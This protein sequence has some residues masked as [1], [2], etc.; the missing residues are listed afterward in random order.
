MDVPILRIYGS[1]I[2]GVRTRAAAIL[3]VRAAYAG[4]SV[5]LTERDAKDYG[6][7]DFLPSPLINPKNLEIYSAN[8]LPSEKFVI[9]LAH[10]WN[11]DRRTELR[12]L[13][14]DYGLMVVSEGSAPKKAK[15]LNGD[16]KSAVVVGGYDGLLLKETTQIAKR[17]SKLPWIAAVPD[18]LPVSYSANMDRAKKKLGSLGDKNWQLPV[19][20]YRPFDVPKG[21]EINKPIWKLAGDVIEEIKPAPADASHGKKP[22]PTKIA[23]AMPAEGPKEDIQAEPKPIPKQD[24]AH[25]I[26]GSG[27]APQ[28]KVAEKIESTHRE[29]EEKRQADKTKRGEID[30]EELEKRQEKERAFE[31]KERTEVERIEARD[32]AAKEQRKAKAEQADIKAKAESSSLEARLDKELQEA[33]QRHYDETG[34]VHEPQQPQ[35]TQ[36]PAIEGQPDAPETTAQASKEEK[37]QQEA[38]ESA[39]ESDLREAGQ[40]NE[41]EKPAETESVAEKA[42]EDPSEETAKT[43]SKAAAEDV[44]DQVETVVETQVEQKDEDEGIAEA[45]ASAVEAGASSTESEEKASAGAIQPEQEAAASDLAAQ[46]QEMSA[47]SASDV[48]TGDQVDPGIDAKATSGDEE[49]VQQDQEEEAS[50]SFMAPDD[51]EQKTPATEPSERK[52]GP[53]KLKKERAKIKVEPFAG[54]D[55]KDESSKEYKITRGQSDNRLHLYRMANI[56]K[57]LKPGNL[58]ETFSKANEKAQFNLPKYEKG[59]DLRHGFAKL[60]SYYLQKMPKQV[61]D[62]SGAY[63]VGIAALLIAQDASERKEYGMEEVIRDFA[64]EAFSTMV[65]SRHPIVHWV[66]NT[67]WLTEHKVAAGRQEEIQ[68]QVNKL[69]ELTYQDRKE[70]LS[71]IQTQTMRALL[72]LA[73]VKIDERL[74]DKSQDADSLAKDYDSV[75]RLFGELPDDVAKSLVNEVFPES[76]SSDIS[77][78]TKEVKEAFGNMA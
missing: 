23:G 41:Q 20:S 4:F 50:L 28:D 47:E 29:F 69:F 21:D 10:T 62:K 37:P 67:L 75:K 19:F 24:L 40:A 54:K 18:E 27:G 43:E 12:D 38:Q 42:S 71:A 78:K 6:L 11:K 77:E 15:D 34:V 72:A 65:S 48:E 9:A 39:G 45:D 16:G 68:A 32:V 58:E 70:Q 25:E 5:V 22:D 76:P 36:E 66:L 30:K 73:L 1:D 59:S 74:N 13:S 56:E 35:Q 44:D 7:R 3:A 14:K 64:N 17:L 57:V 2:G 55:N 60:S 33:R 8:G 63:V 31:E 46:Q 53:I 49:P 51:V 26:L 52:E 61:R